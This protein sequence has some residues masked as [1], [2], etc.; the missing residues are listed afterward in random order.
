DENHW[1]SLVP[2]GEDGETL[3]WSGSASWYDE[4]TGITMEN[5]EWHHLAFSV[6]GGDLDVYLNGELEFSDS[7]FPD[8]FTTCDG[9]FALGVH[10]LYEQSEGLMHDLLIDDGSSTVD[11]IVA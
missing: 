11:Q 10:F 4:T 9:E 6:D 2:M 5:G 3:V 1:V 8:I 7:N